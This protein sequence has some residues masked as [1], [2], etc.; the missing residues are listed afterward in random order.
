MEPSCR[1]YSAKGK[2]EALLL[3]GL[4]KVHT[5]IVRPVTYIHTYINF[6]KVSRY[7]A[8]S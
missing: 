3:K 6:I 5:T 7:L 2:Q 8:K 4:A 1:S